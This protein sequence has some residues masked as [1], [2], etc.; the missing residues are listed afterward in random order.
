MTGDT[1]GPNLKFLAGK[2]ISVFLV[3]G[4]SIKGV[5]I[6]FDQFMN[7]V[8]EDTTLIFGKSKDYTGNTIIRG[9]EIFVIELNEE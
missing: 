5:L 6:G 3:S 8:L 7:L 9:N 1:L 4:V 2:S